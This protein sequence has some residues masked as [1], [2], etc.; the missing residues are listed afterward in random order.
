MI[1][2]ITNKEDLTADYV[3]LELTRR[4]IPFFRFNTEDYPEKVFITLKYSGQAI[5]VKIENKDKTGL[6]VIEWVIYIS[7][8]I[9][10]SIFK[11]RYSSSLNP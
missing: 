11:R 4:N 7:F 5:F 9:Q 6:R 2:I 10:V 3:V 8:S 1:L